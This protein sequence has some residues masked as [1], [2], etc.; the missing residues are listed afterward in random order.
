MNEPRTLRR[1]FEMEITRSVRFS[2]VDDDI[3]VL[4]IGL[5]D[6]PPLNTLEVDLFMSGIIQRVNRDMAHCMID[7]IFGFAGSY[8]QAFSIEY[9]DPASHDELILANM[10][11]LFAI[12]FIADV[13][14]A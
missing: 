8:E 3:F 11:K 14:F 5:I 9:I 10:M 13:Q 7:P 4:Y 12:A 2:T 1:R 6:G